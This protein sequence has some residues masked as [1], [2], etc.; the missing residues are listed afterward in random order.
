MH[1]PAFLYIIDKKNSVIN[2]KL[3]I[4]RDLKL[5]NLMESEAFKVHFDANRMS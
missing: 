5:T 4:E 2:P 3:L 1:Q